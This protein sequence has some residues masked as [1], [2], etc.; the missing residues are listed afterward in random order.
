MAEQGPAGLSPGAESHREGKVLH[1]NQAGSIRQFLQR[2]PLGQVKQ[3]PDEGLLQHWEAQWQEFLRKMESPHSDWGIPQLPEESMPWVD[4]K[5]FLAS[6]EQVAK[7]C[8]WPREEWVA[9]LLPALSGEAERSFIGLDASD[10]EDY[11]K[12]KMAILRGDTMSREEQRQR[13][14]SFCYQAAEGPRG[15]Y[16][17]LQELCQGWLKVERHSKEQILELL[18]LEQFL[19]ILPLEIQSWVRERGPES[20][21]QAVALAEDFLKMQ[22]E[23][24]RLEKEV[25][26]EN[27][28]GSASVVG[29]AL[30]GVKQVPLCM[31]T[32]QED[33]D[34]EALLFD[35]GQASGC[36]KEDNVLEN[37]SQVE[38]DGGV[39]TRAMAFQGYEQ[40]T[41]SGNPC[42]PK[43]QQRIRVYKYCSG[44]ESNACNEYWNQKSLTLSRE[45]F[46]EGSG[47]PKHEKAQNLQH[48]G[49]V[50]RKRLSHKYSL[51]RLQRAHILMKQYKCSVCEKSFSRNSHLLAHERTHTGEKPH[52]CSYCGKSFSHSANLIRHKRIHTGE[53]P[54]KCSYCGKTFTQSS[55]LVLHERI[56]TGEKPYHCST[57]EKS[58][59]RNSF[60]IRHEKTHQGE[61]S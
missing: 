27:A 53:K 17:R 28:A 21:T 40:R 47:L 26:Y 50:P 29:Q 34:R 44:E 51:M 16:S 43:R 24:E 5:G 10:R 36:E 19:T 38:Q 48:Q 6:F 60:L 20:C 8:R 49:T 57:C 9:R 11:G 2:I 33:D 41:T 3:E 14:R 7:A 22:Q 12:V 25:S 18:I 23:A 30:S 15:A 61:K 32:K 35:H 55:H 58:F 45:A 59:A 46:K 4:T 56:H 54:H 13:F 31:E 37:L 1:G 39:W 52:K 42:Q